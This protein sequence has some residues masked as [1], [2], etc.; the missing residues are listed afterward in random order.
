MKSGVTDNMYNNLFGLDLFVYLYILVE[1]FYILLNLSTDL[2]SYS[3]TWTFIVVVF[4]LLLELIKHR[5]W[6]LFALICFY[7]LNLSIDFFHAN[8]ASF[9]VN[10]WI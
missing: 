1:V 8:I 4:L 2:S 7:L 5:N 6:N 3:Y 10:S 9:P